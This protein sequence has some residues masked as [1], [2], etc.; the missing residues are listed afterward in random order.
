MF[1][2]IMKEYKDKYYCLKD[3]DGI[4]T[5][6]NHSFY[7]KTKNKTV[8]TKPVNTI[9]P[10]SVDGDYYQFCSV[11]N[12]SGRRLVNKL[13]DSGIATCFVKHGTFDI[14][15]GHGWQEYDDGISFVF[16]KSSLTP[17]CELFNIKKRQAKREIP[18]EKKQELRERLQSFRNNAK[19]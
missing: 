15:N 10:F 19:Q 6:G 9:T 2:E 18:E 3:E 16:H 17:I 4:W 14:E 12:S 13:L 5:L 11:G 8:P 1:E 7:L